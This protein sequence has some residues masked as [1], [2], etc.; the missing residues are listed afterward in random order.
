MSHTLLIITEQYK[1][2]TFSDIF[3]IKKKRVNYN[4][5]Y[6]QIFPMFI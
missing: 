1:R 5:N 2:S 6:S 4:P 3:S